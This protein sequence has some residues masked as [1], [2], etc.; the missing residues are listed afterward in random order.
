MY[1][2]PTLELIRKILAILGKS[3]DLITFVNDRPGHDR[4]Y[5]MDTSRLEKLGWKATRN[6]DDYL[7]RLK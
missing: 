6:L 7:N 3:D 5:A 1:C 4:R 2:N